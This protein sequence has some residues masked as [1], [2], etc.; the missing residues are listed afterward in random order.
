MT[1]IRLVEFILSPSELIPAICKEGDAKP[2]RGYVIAAGITE[3]QPFGF[4]PRTENLD[5][6]DLAFHIS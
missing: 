1:K 4:D 6:F 2:H 3:L 5:A